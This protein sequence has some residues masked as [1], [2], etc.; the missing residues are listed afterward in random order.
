MHGIY[1]N[2]YEEIVLNVVDVQQHYK[3]A[4]Q[5]NNMLFLETVI[6]WKILYINVLL[7]G[8]VVQEILY[9]L[10]NSS[11]SQEMTYIGN[12]SIETICDVRIL[13]SILLQFQHC[14]SHILYFDWC[15]SILQR[16][17]IICTLLHKSAMSSLYKIPAMFLLLIKKPNHWVSTM[18]YYSDS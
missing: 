17:C 14:V 9:A 12:S 4:N 8:S 3:Y 15:H 10:M 6:L 16:N 13:Q 5:Y 11:M 1:R 2:R 18:S 7:W